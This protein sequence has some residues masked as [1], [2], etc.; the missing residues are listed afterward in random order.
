[1]RWID[2][3]VIVL[4]E[5]SLYKS[6]LCV[7]LDRINVR[8]LDVEGDFGY[9]TMRRAVVQKRL[10]QLATNP[11]TA[12]GRENGQCH[13]VQL[14]AVFFDAGTDGPNDGI[15]ALQVSVLVELGIIA[16]QN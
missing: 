6:K 2:S 13:N 10:Q 1:M 7:E 8:Y 4:N 16:F 15:V 12:V 5:L 14:T 3:F 9:C 11:T